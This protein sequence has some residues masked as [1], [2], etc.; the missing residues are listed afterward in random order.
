MET[1]ETAY[2]KL[3]K[4]VAA[5]I[6]S[7]LDIADVLASMAEGTVK[8]MK[9]KGCAIFLLDW[10]EKTLRLSASAG[11]SEAFLNK[12]PVD[13]EKSIKETL[14]GRR[15]LVRDAANDDR[16]QYPDALRKEG[17]ASILSV[18]ISTRQKIIGV[19]RV[20]AA[21]PRDFSEM[22]YQFIEG[23]AEIGG[24]GIENARMYQH[25]K[26]D[27]ERLMNDVHQWFDYGRAH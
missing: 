2:L 22:E 3:F 12:G 25:L 10:K 1:K 17:V 26:S 4:D 15:V 16:V 27:Y 20:Y 8:T 9:V 6:N 5:K 19:L 14:R 18:P 7:S 13:A 11:L 23:L 21:E 24:I